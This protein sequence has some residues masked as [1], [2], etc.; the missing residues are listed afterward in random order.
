MTSKGRR[1]SKEAVNDDTTQPITCGFVEDNCRKWAQKNLYEKINERSMPFREIV[2]EFKTHKDWK[3]L[4]FSSVCWKKN[5]EK[6]RYSDQMCIDATR[7]I[8]KNRDPDNDYINASWM[9]MPDGRRW[10]STQGPIKNTVE[11]FWHMI[12]TEKVKVIVMLCQFQED[13]VEKSREY[14]NLEGK[15]IEQYGPYKIRVK[16]KSTEVLPTIKMTILECEK[17]KQTTTVHHFWHTSWVDHFCPTEAQTTIGMFKMV[18]EK[19]DKEP[20]VVHCSAGVGRTATFIGI[21]Y[22]SQKISADADTKMVEVLFALRR[23]RFRAIQSQL[24]Y[25]F[26]FQCLAELFMQEGCLKK[27]ENFEKLK[28]NFEA[29]VK[30]LIKAQKAAKDKY[31]AKKAADQKAGLVS[32]ED[33][34][35]SGA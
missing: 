11:D 35:T 25:A 31:Y 8:L 26:L 34:A 2:R 16:T 22:A 29:I 27:D 30:K 7:V 4:Q 24:Q 18:L 10:I 9:T 13:K 33:P 32:R 12:Y 1:G 14:F 6:N 23:M 5:S 19:A 21:D 20:V 28:H 17:D 15:K 3:P